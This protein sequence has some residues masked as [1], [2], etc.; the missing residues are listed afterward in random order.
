MDLIRGRMVDEALAVLRFTRKSVARD[1]LKV[2]R[3]AVANLQQ[4][5]GASGDTDRLWVDECYANQGPSLKRIRP[6]AMGRA[7]RITKRTSHLTVS[8]QEQPEAVTAVAAEASDK[9]AAGPAEKSATAAG[10]RTPRRRRR[11][12]SGR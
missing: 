8:V 2:L 12:R 10:G 5:E 11:G 3:S 1:I 4:R 9:T 7:F 6:A